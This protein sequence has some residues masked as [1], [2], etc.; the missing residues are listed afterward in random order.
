[1]RSVTF[2]LDS[3]TTEVPEQVL[4]L[5]PGKHPVMETHTVPQ[6]RV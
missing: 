3:E 4:E 6:A 2:V 1:M 5:F